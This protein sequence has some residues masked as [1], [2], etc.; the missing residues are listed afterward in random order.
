MRVMLLNSKP[1]QSPVCARTVQLFVPD[2]PDFQK[3]LLVHEK[4]DEEVGIKKP[5]AIKGNK[6]AGSG[7]P[8]G[9]IDETQS[10][11]YLVGRILK[12]LLPIY[13]ISETFFVRMNYNREIELM[14]YLTA[15]TEGIEETGLLINPVRIL[16]E[17][18]NLPEHKVVMVLGQVIAGNVSKRSIE[19]DGCDW[20]DLDKLPH[21]TYLS[22]TCRI[23]RSLK[24]LSRNDLAARV[25]IQW[26]P[27]EE[28]REEVV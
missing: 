19:T 22:H 6:P 21:D 17:E 23:I 13:R 15:I 8:G 26:K 7:L 12:S 11:Q 27:K 16:F 2:T 28:S 20:F 14:L 10:E 9:G 4:G 1:V 24:V 25:T 18:Q 5:N 3:I